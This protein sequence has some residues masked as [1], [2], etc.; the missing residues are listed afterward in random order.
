M[1]TSE[2]VR[3]LIRID[4]FLLGFLHLLSLL[5]PS[6]SQTT[7]F[8]CLGIG[9]VLCLILPGNLGLLVNFAALNF[10]IFF[11]NHIAVKLILFA[12][13][14]IIMY[15]LTDFSLS[16][17]KRLLPCCL[18]GILLFL[19]ACLHYLI[20]FAIQFQLFAVS[21]TAILTAGI[22]IAYIETWKEAVEETNSDTELTHGYKY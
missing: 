13:L 9:L 3:I 1:K 6:L 10:C 17:R 16:K 20:Y 12:I 15:R 21:I 11:T 18:A 19:F 7:L 4:L 8:I 2:K 14:C 5:M 22:A